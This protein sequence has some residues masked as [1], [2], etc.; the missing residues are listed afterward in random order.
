V[1]ARLRR[2]ET[3]ADARRADVLAVIAESFL[4][5]GIEALSGGERHQIVVHVEASVLR[6]EASGCCGL[7]HGPSLP[8]ETARR[9]ACDAS[10]V[11]LVENEKGEPLNVGRSTR[12]IPTALRRALNARDRGCRFPGCPNTRYLVSDRA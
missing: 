8:A 3:P 6:D 7:E 12:T 5:H 11:R 4:K 10:I 2:V 1:N 9:L